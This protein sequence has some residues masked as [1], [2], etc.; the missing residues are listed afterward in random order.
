MELAAL[1]AAVIAILAVLVA[2]GTLPDRPEGYDL[3]STR[4]LPS[5]RRRHT[6]R[7]VLQGGLGALALTA[8]I[9]TLAVLTVIAHSQ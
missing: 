3:Y 7:V 6:R 4:S 9:T 5:T 1:F 2:M 8:G